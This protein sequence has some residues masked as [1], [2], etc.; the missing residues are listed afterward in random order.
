MNVRRDQ[1]LNEWSQ[2][3][4]QICADFLA[5]LPRKLHVEIHYFVRV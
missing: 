5:L 3:I 2:A 1:I 4:D